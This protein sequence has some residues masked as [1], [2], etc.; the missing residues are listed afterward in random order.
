MS[1]KS[2]RSG[3][4]GD[5]PRVDY[6][7]WEGTIKRVGPGLLRYFRDKHIPCSPHDVSDGLM[8]A[9]SAISS[10]LD[11]F[12]PNDKASDQY[13]F[14]AAKNNTLNILRKRLR[15]R[16]LN[17]ELQVFDPTDDEGHDGSPGVERSIGTKRASMLN[18]LKTV[19]SALS[20]DKCQ[21]IL[22]YV[23][24]LIIKT[25]AE[26]QKAQ[27]IRKEIAQKMRDLGHEVPDSKRAAGGEQ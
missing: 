18:D 17:F 11:R 12:D 21:F 27:R 6:A 22:D 20:V 5:P 2:R 8:D 15:E 9:V 7:A 3:A 16:P 25:H 10:Q 14:V 26:R 4:S 1:K 23:Q 24:S 13:L 19:L